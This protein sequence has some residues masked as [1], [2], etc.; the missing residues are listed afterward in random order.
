MSDS[1]LALAR[2][3]TLQHAQQL[4]D[5]ENPT[6]EALLASVGRCPSCAGPLIGL[7]GETV[8]YCAGCGSEVDA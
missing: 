8:R 1:L 7:V 3:L 2:D 6:V 5:G 4:R